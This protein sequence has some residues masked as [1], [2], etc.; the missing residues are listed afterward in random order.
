MNKKR[1]GDR[2]LWGVHGDIMVRGQSESCWLLTLLNGWL[3][4]LDGDQ[5]EFCVCLQIQTDVISLIHAQGA[6]T[7]VK[8]WRGW[9]VIMINIFQKVI[10]LKNQET[11]AGSIVKDFSIPVPIPI[12]WLWYR[13]LN[14]TFIDTN[15][16]KQNEI[17]HYDTYLLMY[18][19]A[20][21][22]RAPSLW[23][24]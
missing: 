20:P 23:L 2:H 12:P 13:F 14:Y 21:T 1:H 17:T 8:E 10:R 5:Q 22:T 3:N 6:L 11:R 24:M 9:A 4:Q 7:W 19:S 16:I 15:F 18:F